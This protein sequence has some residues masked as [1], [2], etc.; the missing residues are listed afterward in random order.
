MQAAGCSPP[1]IP[2]AAGRRS[3]CRAS[4]TTR[5]CS[6]IME[7]CMWPAESAISRCASSTRNL[8]SSASRMSLRISRDWKAA[9]FIRKENT[10]TSMPPMA[11]GP[12]DKLCSARRTSSVRMRSRCSSRRSS[13]ESPTPC[14]REHWSLCRQ[15]PPTV[16]ATKDRASGGPFCRRTSVRWDASRTCNPFAG[17]TTGPSWELPESPSPRV[18][19][20]LR[21][22][23]IP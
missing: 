13:T 4:T 14:T 22:I 19:S 9:T 8:I 2:R 1:P 5:A 10:I 15:R 6:S 3:A 23:H 11:D 21:T 18:A 12:A 20:R 7:R 17:A 16:R